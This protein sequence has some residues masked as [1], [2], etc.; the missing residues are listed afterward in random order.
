MV[1]PVR[2]RPVGA[3]WAG[4]VYQRLGSTMVPNF[5][6]NFWKKFLLEPKPLNWLGKACAAFFVMAALVVAIR[7]LETTAA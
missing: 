2:D 6:E 5:F 4:D 1:E 7:V 3:E